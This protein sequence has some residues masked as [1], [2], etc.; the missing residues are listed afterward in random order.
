MKLSIFDCIPLSLI[1]W[2]ESSSS[3][4]DDFV[5]RRPRRLSWSYAYLPI[6]IFLLPFFSFEQF[7][8]L[9][10]N[11]PIDCHCWYSRYSCCSFITE[12][13]DVFKNQNSWERL[14]GLSS[15]KGQ[16]TRVADS[17]LFLIWENF[18]SRTTPRVENNDTQILKKSLT[19]LNVHVAKSR[20]I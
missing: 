4:E 15:W 17:I 16:W 2:S 8:L 18:P 10:S 13:G 19:Q 11:D 3:E 7:A 12:A 14:P 6:K 9:G 20:I 1:S 5:S